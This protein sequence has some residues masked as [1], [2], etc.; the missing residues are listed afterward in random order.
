MKIIDEAVQALQKVFEEPKDW[1]KWSDQRKK[2]YK[3]KHP[4]K[5]ADDRM[6]HHTDKMTGYHKK[7]ADHLEKMKYH[8]NAAKD[9]VSRHGDN[10]TPEVKQQIDGHIAS[11]QAHQ[12]MHDIHS[13]KAEKHFNRFNTIKSDTQTKKTPRKIA[14]RPI[15]KER[16]P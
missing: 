16:F 7:A 8:T 14:N 10:I 3:E 12:T 5:S 9:L 11:A 2:T 4:G 6:Q 13:K 1:S 15:P